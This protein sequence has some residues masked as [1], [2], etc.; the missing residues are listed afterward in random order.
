MLEAL[1]QSQNSRLIGL[2]KICDTQLSPSPS[3]RKL[4]LE[5]VA[6]APHNYSKFN[7]KHR[8]VKDGNEPLSAFIVPTSHEDA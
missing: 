4:N 8:K 3:A 2:P 1:G 6:V 7:R 5:M